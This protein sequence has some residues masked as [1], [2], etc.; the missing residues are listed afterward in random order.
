MARLRAHGLAVRHGLR[1]PFQ[2]GPAHAGR[3]GSARSTT[4]I[5]DADGARIVRP[6][7]DEP[8][9]LDELAG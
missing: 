9:S 6:G 1:G 5:V 8:T 7:G 2:E 3:H 4:V